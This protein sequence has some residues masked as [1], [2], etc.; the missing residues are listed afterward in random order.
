[1]GS[2]NIPWISLSLVNA[3]DVS[4]FLTSPEVPLR[5]SP[6]ALKDATLQKAIESKIQI[7]KEYI[8]NDLAIYM[9]QIVPDTVQK[10][11][12][13]KRDQLNQLVAN[14]GRDMDLLSRAAGLPMSGLI[15]SGTIISLDFWLMLMN[16]ISPMT[17]SSYGAPTSGLLGDGSGSA[18]IGAFLVDVLNFLV[19]IN[20]STDINAPQWVK[21]FATNAMD[22]LLFCGYD[23][24][25]KRGA[26][27][28]PALYLTIHFMLRDG[29]LA[30]RLEYDTTP[31]FKDMAQ[32]Y[33]A[34]YQ[35]EFKKNKFL[36]IPDIDEDGK[37]SDF[38]NT[39][40]NPKIVFAM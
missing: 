22:N 2:T 14:M 31:F 19:Y 36:V 34:D 13:H 39:L 11:F 5:F 40:S 8:Y 6:N 26:M 38:E 18:L 33:F 27:F 29:S 24:N 30:G 17:F 3:N 20:T 7:A 21:L 35:K 1:M 15:E 28:F 16:G 23:A 37:V 9:R 4:T 25:M 12:A 10:W 32:S